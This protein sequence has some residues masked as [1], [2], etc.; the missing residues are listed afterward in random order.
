MGLSTRVC[1]MGS[2]ELGPV[3]VAALVG[4]A[5]LSE[6]GKYCAPFGSINT[7]SRSFTSAFAAAGSPAGSIQH[8]VT[9]NIGKL[10]GTST[11]NVCER[12][13]PTAPSANGELDAPVRALM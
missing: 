13:L 10:A 12:P 6:N 5:A 3:F 8:S 4:D 9:F 11:L 7:M 1:S 2:T